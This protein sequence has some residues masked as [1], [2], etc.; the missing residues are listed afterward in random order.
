MDEVWMPI[1]GFEGLYE[2]SNFG[3][4]KSL[5]RTRITKAGGLCLVRQQFL[6]VRSDKDGYKEVALSKG[7]KLY[8]FRVHRLVAAAF[9][10]NPN[11]LPVINHIDE[12]P[13]N[14]NVSNLE[15]CSVRYNNRYSRHKV[16]KPVICNG[17]EYP[18]IRALSR[19][20]GVDAKSIRAHLKK[21]GAIKGKYIVSL[22]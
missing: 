5:A 8:Y 2:I 13:A 10:P 20:I 1:K 7:A 17:V 14:N 16:S 11:H 19:S 18:S 21:G 9:I 15:W 6:R 22:P 12:N 4:V 3:R